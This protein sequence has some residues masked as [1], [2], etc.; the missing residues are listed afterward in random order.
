[1]NHVED[2]LQSLRNDQK[3]EFRPVADMGE[4]FGGN[5]T[6]RAV[7]ATLQGM[8]SGNPFVQLGSLAIPALEKERRMAIQPETGLE[9]VVS[10]AAE[11]ATPAGL[12]AKAVSSMLK[13]PRVSAVLS[14]NRI[15]RGIGSLLAPAAIPLEVTGAA[16]GGGAS[17]YLQPE[18]QL[19]KWIIKNIGKGATIGLGSRLLKK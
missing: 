6:G 12:K 17:S 13:V 4:F 2:I 15:G 3:K 16:I 5:P 14:N 18:T 7:T 8:N 10:G 19:E 1:M 11:F 9:R